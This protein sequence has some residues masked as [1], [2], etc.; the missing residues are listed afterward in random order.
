MNK[1]HPKVFISYSWDS[2]EHK[3]WVVELVNKLRKN[4]VDATC[5]QF[6]TQIG[7]V[8]LNKMMVSAFKDYDFV[9]IVL[10]ES[11]AKKAE[12][13][14]G[15]VGF[16]TMLSL[17]ILK[18]NPDDLILITREGYQNTFPSHLEGFYALDFSDDSKF[19]EKI[20]E[21]V[22]RIFE[23]PKL[24]KEPLGKIPD[25]SK[26]NKSNSSNTSNIDIDMSDLKDI[27]DEDKIKFIKNNFRKICEELK[28]LLEK[29][30][31]DNSSFTYSYDKVTEKKKEFKIFKNGNFKT[32]IKIWLDSSFG[33]SVEN[34]CI[35]YGRITSNDN[36]KNEI[37]KVINDNN[38]LML[39]TTF[40]MYG[41]ITTNDV[42]EIIKEMWENHISVH[43]K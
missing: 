14:E 16:E 18:E 43:L 23:V 41:N 9:I 11:Y 27:T 19:D 10:T 17:P 6:E 28:K 37:I 25:F 4:G 2:E 34:I 3:N 22:H 24:E 42:N 12:N 15:G 13:G 36:S 33:S 1:N 39:K 5:D 20:D 31:S 8:N 21:L 40:N 29:V 7:N 32:G 30:Q 26:N 38:N 35:S